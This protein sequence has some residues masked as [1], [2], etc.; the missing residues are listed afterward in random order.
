MPCNSA[1]RQRRLLATLIAASV[2]IVAAAALLSHPTVG[3]GAASAQVVV[4]AD[5]YVGSE[6]CAGCHQA[7][8]N[9]WRGSH[10]DLAMQH[11]DDTTVLGDFDDAELAHRGVTSRFTR[12]GAAFVVTTEGPDGALEDFEIA[13]VFGVEPVQ[14]YLVPFPGGRYQALLVGWDSR[15]A[16]MGGQRWVDLE[17]DEAIAPGDPL[18]W[19]GRGFTWNMM[20]ADCHSTNVVRNYDPDSGSYRTTFSEI[21]VGC[22]ACHGPGQAHTDWA[23]AGGPA[24]TQGKGLA[25][26]FPPPATWVMDPETGIAQ[27]DT[28]AAGGVELQACARCHSRRAPLSDGSG[29]HRPFLDDYRIGLLRSDLYHPDGQILD[30]VFVLGSFLQS[31]MH[32]A[33]VRCSNCHEPHTLALR[34]TGNALCAQ[35]HEPARFDTA[36]H[37]FHEADS[38]GAACVE[39][40][41]PAQTYLAVD[42][43]R[44]HSFRIPR[45]DLSLRIGTPNAC[46]QCHSDKSDGWAEARLLEW[47]GPAPATPHFG[48]VLHAVRRGEAGAIDR[49]VALAADPA[50]AAIVRATALSQFG[51]NPG[52][53]GYRVLADNARADDP[54]LRLAVA[55][56]LAAIAPERRI[57]IAAPLLGDPVRAVRVAAARA[58]APVPPQGVPADLRVVLDRATDEFLAAQRSVLDQ[59]MTHLDLGNFHGERGRISE[60][61]AAFRNALDLQPSF[62]AARLNLADLYRATGRDDLAEDLVREAVAIDPEDGDAQH[63]LG[64]VLVRQGRLGDAIDPLARAAALNPDSARYGLIYGLA[65]DGLGDVAGALL[66]L[67]NVHRRHPGDRQV[68]ETLIDLSMRAGDLDAALGYAQALVAI[69]PRDPLA[70]EIFRGIERLAQPR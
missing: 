20:C 22:E 27:S 64:L 4:D 43:R 49:L 11:A 23:A 2:L 13:F 7:E 60:A 18:H 15:P 54:L 62:N 35:C 3:P 63:A 38:A 66:A 55:D 37:H 31:R 67:E 61:E 19:T 16:D 42:E 12:R 57:V 6:T 17:A 39:C 21:D 51:P 14:Q 69:A 30:E 40:H 44:D 10:H 32:R 34:A 1:L 36:E 24:G 29:P 25:V 9:A 59:P 45:P 5:G 70:R 41:M 8:H 58:M 52:P 50:Q 53:R 68:L 33:G 46:T 65:L 56:A 26:R 47:H 28:D 48:E